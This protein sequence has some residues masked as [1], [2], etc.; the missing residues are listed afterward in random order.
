MAEGRRSTTQLVIH[1]EEARLDALPHLGLLDRPPGDSFDRI[2]RMASRL[3]GAPVSAISLTD[4]DRQWFESGV[5]VDL[6]EIPRARAPC[7]YAIGSDEVSV[8]PDMLRDERFE[9]SPLARAGIR[10][11]AGPR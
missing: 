9:T 4:R 10:F 1:N 7:S 11:Y 8:V 2:T 3:L 5:E 6:V